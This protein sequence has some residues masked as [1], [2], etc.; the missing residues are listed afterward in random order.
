VARAASCLDETS[1][2]ETTVNTAIVEAPRRRPRALGTLTAVLLS[3]A[4]LASGCA[5]TS[6]APDGEDNAVLIDSGTTANIGWDLWAWEDD[7]ALCMGMGDEAG[8]TTERNPAAAGSMSGSQ[9]GFNDKKQGAT[10]YTSAQNA[11]NG[12]PTVALVFGPLPSAAVEIQ[13][14]SKIK[15]KTAALPTG[16]DLPT[17]HYW[18]WAGPYQTPAS[19]GTLL[20]V[21]KPLDAQG[22]AVA[23]Q[24]Y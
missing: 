10:Y 23:F 11:G 15:L 8:P 16:A 17:A 4:A 22:K 1:P 18:V 12:P 2:E 14:T 7:G 13:V 6:P 3:C 19:D 24:S 5:S 20:A 21:P 9:C